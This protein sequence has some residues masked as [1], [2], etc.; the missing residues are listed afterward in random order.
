[1]CV[2]LL[3]ASLAFLAAA[4]PAPAAPAADREAAWLVMLRSWSGGVKPARRA[5][6][7]TSTGKAPRLTVKLSLPAR[8]AR[9]ET[10]PDGLYGTYAFAFDGRRWRR[11]DTADFRT[12]EVTVLHPGG[13]ATVRLPVE[14]AAAYRVLVRTSH[15]AAWAD[16]RPRS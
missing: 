11:V 2:A 9:A 13:R 14:K 1:A 3:S 5:V 4:C 8:A 7:L 16:A 10:F 15:G 12:T 6:T